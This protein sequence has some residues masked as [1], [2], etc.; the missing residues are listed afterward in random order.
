MGQPPGSYP[1]GGVNLLRRR[2]AERIT[3]WSATPS[4]RRCKAGRAAVS[5]RRP[6]GFSMVEGPHECEEVIGVPP[7][8]SRFRCSAA[9]ARYRPQGR[10][11]RLSDIARLCARGDCGHSSSARALSAAIL[12]CD[13]QPGAPAPPRGPANRPARL[14]ATIWRQPDPPNPAA[15]AGT[16]GAAPVWRLCFR[17]R[18]AG[19]RWTLGSWGGRDPRSRRRI[20]VCPSSVPVHT[21]VR[22][23]SWG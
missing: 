22:A 23:F 7:C 18:P 2:N 15:V 6:D 11:T 4:D 12:G 8:T 13:R 3:G 1:N 19:S 16:R 10:T 14:H 21:S 20:H 9:M 5:L 17:R